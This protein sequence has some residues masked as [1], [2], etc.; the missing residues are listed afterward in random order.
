V[1]VPEGSRANGR[2]ERWEGSLE[3]IGEVAALV[4]GCEPDRVSVRK[5]AFVNRVAIRAAC[6]G[7][8][9][10]VTEVA[11]A[12]GIAQSTASAV[13]RDERA[14]GKVVSEA[15]AVASLLRA[16]GIRE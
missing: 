7:L 12:L 5:R 14:K 6:L 4:V 10:T 1:R 2:V 9:R 8:G 3:G 16:G 13:M 11:D 15:A